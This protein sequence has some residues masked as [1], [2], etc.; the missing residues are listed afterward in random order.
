MDHLTK[1][2]NELE[3]EV[4]SNKTIEHYKYNPQTRDF[5][6]KEDKTSK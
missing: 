5:F 6:K 1:L 4:I 3:I 2:N